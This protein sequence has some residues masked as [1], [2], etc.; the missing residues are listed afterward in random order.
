MLHRW[1]KK[2][3]YTKHKEVNSMRITEE[4]LNNL[5]PVEVSFIYAGITKL[6]QE[7]IRH[8]TTNYENLAPKIER[9]PHCGSTHD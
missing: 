2:K 8:E 1:C 3:T 5:T 6:Y 7:K 9:C 4:F